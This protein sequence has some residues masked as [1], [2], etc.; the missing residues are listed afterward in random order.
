MSGHSFHEPRC[1]GKPKQVLYYCK[2]PLPCV[3]CRPEIMKETSVA[4]KKL[5]LAV[6]TDIHHGPT[7]FT[8]LGAFAVPLLEDFRDRVLK[9][10]V[11]LVVDLGDRISNV[12]HDTDLGLMRDVMSVFEGMETRHEHLL[13]NHDLHYLS[14]EENEAILGCSLDSH[15]FDLKGWHLIFWQLNL[16]HGYATNITPSESE[17]EW[18]S[19]DLEKTT[20]PSIIFTHIPLNNGAMI[21]NYYFQNHIASSTVQHTSDAREII[22]ASGNV[23]MCVAG[24]VHWNDSSTIDGIRYL[25]LQSLTESYTTQTEAS[26][27]WAEI[28][29]DDQVHWRAHGNDSMTYQ[30]PVRGLNMHWTPPRPPSPI[31]SRMEMHLKFGG[32]I[33]GVV[34]DMDGV[35]FRGAQVIDGSVEAVRDLQ[36]HGIGVVCLTNNAR[37]T[38]DDYAGKLRGMGFDINASNIVTSGVATARYLLTQD[39][40]PKIH[41]VGSA[42][43]RQTLRDAGA[44]ESESPDFVVVGIELDMKISDLISAV[45]YVANGARLIASNG[46]VVIPTTGGPEPET[47]AVIAFL[48]AA[49]GVQATVV[50]KPKPEIFKYAID[51]L[52]IARD[53]IVMIGDTLATDVAGAKAAGLC[54]ILVASGNSTPDETGGCEP[55]ARFAD[56]RAAADFLLRR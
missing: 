32:A 28:D 26:G 4:K 56:L 11:D 40:E 36:T 14:R 53:E 23:V 7:R 22:E 15:S 55:T 39:A 10:D 51:L 9:L 19:K 1:K 50:G 45:R 46:D 3:G 33:N 6:V 49:T 5:K 37:G 42:V 35:L 8:K 17:L 31:P 48:E 24:H 16:S 47:G 30:A 44:V 27:A 21:G 20:H 12:D 38:P 25:T 43:L 13:G 52:G 18:L 54:S 2:L 34:L 29:I 41:A